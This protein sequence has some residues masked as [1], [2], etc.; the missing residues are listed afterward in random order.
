[1]FGH[2]MLAKWALDPFVI[3]LNHGTV[4]APPRRV[5]EA[6]RK[7]RDEIELQPSRF[8]LRELAGVRLGVAPPDPPRLRVAADAVAGFLGA[9]GKDLVF[10]DNATSGANAVLRCLDFREADE[11]LI[12]DQAYGAVRNAGEY[13]AR[14]RGAHLRV[15]ET[16]DVHDGPTR[17]AAAVEAQISPR[18]RLLMIDHVV[19]ENGLVLPV[20]EIASRCH[21]HGVRVLVDGAH[22]PGAIPLNIESLGVDWYVGNLHK[23]AWSPR[24]SGILWIHPSQQASL[25]H[26]VTSWGLDQGFI[27][28]FDWPG[29]R[30]PTPHL[31]AP[32]G[33]AY[34]RE[35]GVERVQSHNHELAY[36]AGTTMADHW[37]CRLLGPKEM[38]GTMVS[39]PLPER[40]GSSA[41][42]AT[43]L[44]DFLLFEDNIEVHTYA[45]ANRVHVR[46]SAQ[47]YNEMSDVERLID[48]IDRRL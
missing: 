20:A 4:G 22:A 12:L 46:V 21:N 18:T 34:M 8:L 35:L 16:P 6:Q 14:T 13:V 1:M 7:L 17:F 10:V 45:R 32:E 25:H 47:I 33:I 19:S 24:S 23:W 38:I 36:R 39:V 31:A 28:E 5:L 40:A 9:Q 44:R 48:V 43:R 3:Y 41:E 2:S 30:D 29:T 15:M 26:P 42:D 37:K 27:L 11:I